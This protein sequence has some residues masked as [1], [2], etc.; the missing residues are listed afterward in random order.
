MPTYNFICKDCGEEGEKNVS[1][2]HFD[3]L[4]ECPKCGKME[5]E[6]QFSPSNRRNF[7]IVGFCYENVYGKK[8]YKRNMSPQQQSEVLTGDRSPY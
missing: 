5:W 6:R 3:E 7:D 4:Q 1:L 2:A 8:A